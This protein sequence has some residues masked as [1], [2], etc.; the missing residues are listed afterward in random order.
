MSRSLVEL[1]PPVMNAAGTCKTLEQFRALLATP[2]QVVVAGSYTLQDRS[3][4]P[5]GGPHLTELASL[6]SMGLPSPALPEWRRLVHEMATLAYDAGKKVWVSVAGFRPDEYLD[7]A[8]A[9]LEAGADA[10]E[11][12][13]GCPNVHDGGHQKPIISYDPDAVDEIRFGLDRRVGLKRVGAKLSPIFDLALMERVDSALGGFSWVTT[14][15]TVPNCF[16]FLPT[17]PRTQAIGF[18]KG[19]AGMSGQAVKWIGLG[20]VVCHSQFLSTPIIGVGGIESAGDVADYLAVGAS[21]CQVGTAIWR[22]GPSVLATLSEN[23]HD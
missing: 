15:N 12:N 23:V 8:E 6:N 18:S 4:N 21:A 1:T 13:L 20:Q 11:V 17:V 16:A 7:L 2:A 14:M 3:G 9:A 22:H 5:G 10:V 19:L